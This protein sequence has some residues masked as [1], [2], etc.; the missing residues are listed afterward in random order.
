M[1]MYPFSFVARSWAGAALHSWMHCGVYTAVGWAIFY[2]KATAL[3]TLTLFLSFVLPH[4][5][6]PPR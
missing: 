6:T 4:P 1:T 2:S 3:D 5:S